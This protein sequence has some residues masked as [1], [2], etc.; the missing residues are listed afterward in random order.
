MKLNGALNLVESLIKYGTVVTVQPRVDPTKDEIDVIVS[1]RNKPELSQEDF[2]NI[3]SIT[4]QLDC[5]ARYVNGILV[6]E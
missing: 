6:Y 1:I 3:S 4:K 2:D 5:T